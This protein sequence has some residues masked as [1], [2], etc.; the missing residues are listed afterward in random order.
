MIT[1]APM[2]KNEIAKVKI[3]RAIELIEVMLKLGYDLVDI[4][5]QQIPLRNILFAI[6]D[7]FS[8]LFSSILKVKFYFY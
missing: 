5:K 3:D 2:F 8:E 7:E 1:Y 6:R 4:D